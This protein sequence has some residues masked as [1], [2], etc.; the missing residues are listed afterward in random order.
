M[1]HINLSLP[2]LRTH[3]STRVL[4]QELIYPPSRQKAQETAVLTKR[5]FQRGATV[6]HCSHL[7]ISRLKVRAE[8]ENDFN[9]EKIRI[10]GRG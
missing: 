9:R 4:G 3:T 7:P 6:S 5:V 1:V 8:C 10:T 2:E